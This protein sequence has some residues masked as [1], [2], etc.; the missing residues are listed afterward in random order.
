MS[1]ETKCAVC[2]DVVMLAK[3]QT[4]G[5]RVACSRMRCWIMLNKQHKR[6]LEENEQ[7]PSIKDKK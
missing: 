7:V 3:D 1:F 5:L 4:D 2:G 6:E